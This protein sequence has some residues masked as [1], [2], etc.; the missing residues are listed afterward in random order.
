MTKHVLFKEYND[1]YHKIGKG[2]QGKKSQLYLDMS[3]LIQ[4]HDKVS[5][6][7]VHG[8]SWMDLVYYSHKLILNGL[9]LEPMKLQ[10]LV[11]IVY[12]KIISNLYNGFSPFS[13]QHFSNSYVDLNDN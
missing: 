9:S 7:W 1:K 8:V 13:Y 4:T 3:I 11:H 2:T 6:C 12:M 5:F 10:K